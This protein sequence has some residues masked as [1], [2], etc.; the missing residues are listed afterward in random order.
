M[1]QLVILITMFI[2]SL[3]FSQSETNTKPKNP[4]GQVIIV[5]ISGIDNNKGKM[6]IGL[7]TSEG[8]WLGTPKKALMSKIEK[9]KSTAT[10]TNIPEGIYAISVFHDENDNN[11]I[12]MNFMGIPKEDNGCSNGARGF[13]GPPKW[14]DAKFQVKNETITQNI[15]L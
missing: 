9:G 5:N 14:K 1:Q 12:D 2:T 3:M 13:F 7:Y 15:K 6:M 4:N 11:K 8:N 10:F